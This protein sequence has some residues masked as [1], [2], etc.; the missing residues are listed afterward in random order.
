[1]HPSAPAR[2]SG[3]LHTSAAAAAAAVGVAVV[4]H[5]QQAALHVK[6]AVVDLHNIDHRPALLCRS[7]ASAA[8]ASAA[9]I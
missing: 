7:Q 6:Q 8:A 5:L 9:A 3:Y 1:V 4:R 2:F